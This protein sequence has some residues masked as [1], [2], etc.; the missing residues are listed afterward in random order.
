MKPLHAKDLRSNSHRI[1]MASRNQG[2]TTNSDTEYNYYWYFSIANIIIA[3]PG[4][5]LN[6]LLSFLLW[7]F[8]KLNTISFRFI[9][10]LSV[11]DIIVGITLVSSRTV[12]LS[13]NGVDFE[14]IKTYSDI[15]CDT[16]CQFSYTTVLLVAID[17]YF[18]MRLLTRYSQVMTKKRAL[19]LILANA[20]I[21]LSFLI[22][23][24]IGYL[25]G[26]YSMSL[27]VYQLSAIFFAVTVSSIYC[28]TFRSMEKRT[29]QLN[30]ATTNAPVA[31]KRRDPTKEFQKV[32]ILILT[33]MALCVTP[34]AVFSP[35]QFIYEQRKSYN[36]AI[37]VWSFLARLFMCFNSTLNA[38]IFLMVNQELK[39][40]LLGTLGCR[41]RLQV[42]EGDGR[43][44]IEGQ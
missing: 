39:G 9:F 25:K 34:M 4:I 43:R 11:S 6:S 24:I 35:V 18:H 1:A 26:F 15:A 22:L 19:I 42:I 44:N 29:K 36:K 14:E 23:R 40:F 2:A 7:K 38:T 20:A 27:T 5:F 8:K 30:L 32:M 33:A 37:T 10:I 31:V 13:I 21:C 41:K 3:I 28:H 12:F 17:R 16:L